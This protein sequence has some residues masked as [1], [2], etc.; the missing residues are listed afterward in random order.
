MRQRY[1]SVIALK[2]DA[3][4]VYEAL[5]RAVPTAVLDTIS[6]CNVTNYSIYRYGTL[7][8]SYFEYVGEDY[9]ADMQ[10]MADDVATQEWWSVCNPLQVQVEGAA[11]GSWWSMV[12]EVFHVD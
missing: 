3:I 4:E 1:G 11:P 2:P 10:K 7:L 5:H 6:R 9:E 12:P 8:F